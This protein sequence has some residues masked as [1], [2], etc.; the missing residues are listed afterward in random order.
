MNDEAM[1]SMSPDAAP[2]PSGC[3]RGG[4]S[5]L[6]G[7]VADLEEFWPSRRAHAFDQRCR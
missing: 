7:V 5:T 3:R 1:T 4:A 2:G 6:L